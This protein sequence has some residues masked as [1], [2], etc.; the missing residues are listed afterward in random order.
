MSKT[1]LITGAGSGFGEGAAIGLA[2][3]GHQVIATAEISPQ[4]AALRRKVA[5]IERMELRLGESKRQ[6]HAL[7][8]KIE[9]KPKGVSCAGN[10]KRLLKEFA[11]SKPRRDDVPAA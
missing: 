8:R 2:R 3:N 1:I 9:S 5:H 11:E 6:L 10:A 4:V 7:I